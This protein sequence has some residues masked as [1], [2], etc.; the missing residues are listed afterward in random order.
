M[1][2]SPLPSLAA[3][4]CFEAAAR[5][6]SFTRAAEELAMTQAA[7]SYQVKLLEE[8][9]G[10]PLFLRGPR[11]VTLSDAGRRLA[12]AVSDA[13]AGLR[14]A[15]QTLDEGDTVLTITSLATFANNWLVPH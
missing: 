3:I 10:A 8:R 1:T 2:S 4:R 5:H 15:F 11:G 12:P 9:I 13:F 14:A 7:V 6:L